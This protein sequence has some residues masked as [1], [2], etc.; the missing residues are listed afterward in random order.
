MHYTAPVPEPR[1]RI[2]A[3]TENEGALKIRAIGQQFAPHLDLYH[4]ILKRSWV[5]YGFMVFAAFAALN[6]FFATLYWL[7]PGSI[8]NARPQSFEDAFFF[9]V[10]TFATI[11]YGGMYPAT[12]YAHFAVTFEA[13]TGMLSVALV[14]GV[15]FAKFARPTARVLF[16][17]KMVILPRNGVPHLMMRMANWRHNN[18]VD[19]Q[20]S[21]LILVNE[22]TREGETMRLPI[23]LPLVRD[24]SSVFGLSWTAMHTIDEKSPFF[25]PDAM[26]RLR[27]LGGE[28]YLSLTGFDQTMAGTIHTRKRYSLDDI[29]INARFADV[30]RVDP[31]GTRVIDYRNFHDVV[32]IAPKS[33][34]PV[35]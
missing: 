18:I 31:D 30:I 29:V 15:T 25:G 23:Y 35:A 8:A 1:K 16:A 2:A 6:V 7:R 13:F 20:L 22:R 34:P 28:I 10:Q 19:A 17:E 9:S 11:G 32:P 12:R 14:T 4:F 24:Q 3:P 33:T 21:V 26:E 27:A 5:V